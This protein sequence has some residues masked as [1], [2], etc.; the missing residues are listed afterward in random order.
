MWEGVA[1]VAA[2]AGTLTLMLIEPPTDALWTGGILFD[3]A[4]RRAVRLDNEQSHAKVASIG[5]IPYFAAPLLPLI[6]DPLLA[7]AVHGDGKAALNMELMGLEAF[8]YAGFMSFVSTR[9]S[10]RERP[11]SRQCREDHPES[12]CPPT[13]TEAFWSGHTSI[14]AASAGLVCANHVY[15]PLWGHPIADAGAC[16]LATSGAILTGVTRLMAD[17]HYTTDV[18]VGFGMGFGFGYAVPALLHY[19][20][21]KVEV[22]LGV[23]PGEC[24]GGCLTLNGKF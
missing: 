19:S 6:V 8:S 13:D 12:G 15:M 16:V 2:G 3:D 11:D 4:I 5:D 9:T 17:R 22:A 21:R 18:L 10:R 20:H 23:R 7:W 1:T 24:T 14:V